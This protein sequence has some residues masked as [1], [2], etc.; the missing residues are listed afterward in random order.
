MTITKLG[1]LERNR[2]TGGQIQVFGKV[3]KDL[4]AKYINVFV[5]KVVK[6]HWRPNR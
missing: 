3:V 5:W 1:P 2:K 4:E 6:D